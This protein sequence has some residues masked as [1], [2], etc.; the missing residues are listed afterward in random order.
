MNV[1]ILGLVH[2][3]SAK[4][5]CFTGA[6]SRIECIGVVLVSPF[7]PST[8][9]LSLSEEI[10]SPS[11]ISLSLSEEIFSFFS[12]YRIPHGSGKQ[13]H[14]QACRIAV[15]NS[16]YQDTKIGSDRE[17]GKAGYGLF[18]HISG[19]ANRSPMPQVRGGRG[20]ARTLWSILMNISGWLN[21]L[22][23]NCSKWNGSGS[24]IPRVYFWWRLFWYQTP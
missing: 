20:L 22:T 16:D 5:L 4:S 15:D 12:H 2:C 6:G 10:F 13:S 23:P 11:T 24:K 18:V 17:R 19:A 8:I 14:V 9:S 3:S 7:P 1:L 21:Y